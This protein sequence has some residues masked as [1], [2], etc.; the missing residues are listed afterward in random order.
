MQAILEDRARSITNIGWRREV[1]I[2]FSCEQK[3]LGVASRRLSRPQS[4][5]TPARMRVYPSKNW[6]RLTQSVDIVH[7]YLNYEYVWISTFIDDGIGA[8][9]LTARP[10]KMSRLRLFDV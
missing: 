5:D 8:N 1:A 10:E 2:E 6:V 7:E 4:L 3:R 9:C